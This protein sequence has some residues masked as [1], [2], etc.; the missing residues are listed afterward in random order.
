MHMACTLFRLTV[1]EMLASVTRHAARAL[2]LQATHGV[3]GSGRP[4]NFVLWKVRA[5]AE[6]AYWLGARPVSTIVRQGR[7]ALGG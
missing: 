2:G 1:P 7:I 6:I 5:P 4:A 3:L